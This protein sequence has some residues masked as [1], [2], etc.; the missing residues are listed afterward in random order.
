MAIPGDEEDTAEMP[1]D[2]ED[3]AE[4]TDDEGQHQNKIENEV[5]AEDELLDDEKAL[6]GKEGV[7][8]AIEKRF[9]KKKQ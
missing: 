9:V 6:N 7:K 4:M 8:D 1:G 5:L 3:K 2:E